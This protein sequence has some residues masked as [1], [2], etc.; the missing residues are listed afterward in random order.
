[1]HIPSKRLQ[2]VRGENFEAHIEYSQNLVAIHLPVVH[3]FDRSTFL[4]MKF[5][6]EDWDT[7]F[8]TVGYEETYVAFDQNNEKMIKLVD[9]LKF[10]YITDN[11]GLSI[12]RYV[13]D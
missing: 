13:G 12:F 3:K 2:G 9:M 5:M 6:L 4:E 1:M 8:K 10:E 11:E 7:F